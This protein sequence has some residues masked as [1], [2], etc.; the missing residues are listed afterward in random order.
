MQYALVGFVVIDLLMSCGI[1]GVALQYMNRRDTWAVFFLGMAF[2]PVW[3]IPW[4]IESLAIS[5][6]DTARRLSYDFRLSMKPERKEPDRISTM[7]INTGTST[8][9]IVGPTKS[10]WAEWAKVI[11]DN[12]YR[13]TARIMGDDY[14]SFRAAIENTRYAEVK[15]GL[16]LTA[17]G[18]RMID[19]L[20]S[21]TRT[22]SVN[23]VSGRVT[24]TGTHYD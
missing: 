14:N 4:I 12:N 8:T 24:H 17:E 19:K 5:T 11:K 10:K 20:H 7:Y 23:T 21:P 1:A 6:S 15:N 9:R 2:F 16:Q 22:D 13:C 18:K 3:P